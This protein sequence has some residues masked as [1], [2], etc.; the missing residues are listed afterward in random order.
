MGNVGKREVLGWM[1]LECEGLPALRSR[2]E[3]NLE[4]RQFENL[5]MK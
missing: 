4:M 3:D 2:T 5:E 1:N